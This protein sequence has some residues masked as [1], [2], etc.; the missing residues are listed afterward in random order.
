[1][2]RGDVDAFL[3]ECDDVLEDWTPGADAA[4]WS[5]AGEH[6]PA[7]I[8]GG[9][10]WEDWTPERVREVNRSRLTT[11]VWQGRVVMHLSV[12]ASQMMRAVGDAAARA[13]EEISRVRMRGLEV[14]QFWLDEVQILSPALWNGLLY[15]EPEP[16][17]P[18]PLIL[19]CPVATPSAVV[20]W[21]LERERRSASSASTLPPPEPVQGPRGTDAQ[22]S[23]YGPSDRR[24]ARRV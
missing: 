16:I 1:M 4:G 14:T 6:Q 2:S 7:A 24:T 5:A 19:R 18:A 23:P 17:V 22:R 3:A 12:D 11:G 13:D 20:D 8:S 9:A 21:A 15:P 10:Y